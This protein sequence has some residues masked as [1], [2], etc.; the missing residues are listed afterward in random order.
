MHPDNAENLRMS[1]RRLWMAGVVVLLL[2][3]CVAQWLLAGAGDRGSLLV[4]ARLW[5]A[6]KNLYGDIFQPSLPLIIWLYAVP[7]FLSASTG[8]TAAHLLVLLTF[9]LCLLSVR[10]C[11]RLIKLHP[12]FAGN[13]TACLHHSIFLLCLFVFF[14]N[15]MFF[16]DREHLIVVLMFPLFLRCMPSLANQALTLPLRIGIGVMAAL[17]ACIKPHALLLLAGALALRL[18]RERFI[19]VLTGA[20]SISIACTLSLYGLL[21]WHFTSDYFSVVLPMLLKTYSA[22]TKGPE[23]IQYYVTSGFMLAVTLADFRLR[24]DSPYRKDILY[25]LG[26]CVFCL[27]YILVNN[28]WIYTF[29]PLNCIILLLAAWVW[30]EFRWLR[31]KS[32]EQGKDTR[33][34]YSGGMA[35]F[36]TMAVNTLAALLGCLGWIHAALSPLPSP[37]APVYD[38]MNRMITDVHAHS[39]GTLS[40]SFSFWPEAVDKTGALMGTRFNHLWMLPRF[41]QA[42]DA[43]TKENAWIL[44]YV[45]DAYAQDLTRNKPEIVFVDAGKNFARTGKPL[46]LVKYFSGYASF[47][48]AWKHYA[49]A[50]TIDH[51]NDPAVT[52]IQD[53]EV[54]CR[55]DV[56]ERRE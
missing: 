8:I 55:Q 22:N 10:I 33:Q 9:A 44:Q 4:S 39:F 25:F 21:M 48:D 19:A 37:R 2:I 40:A 17:G 42:D 54:W 31:Q 41:L 13:A 27:S 52:A 20:E 30:K 23:V 18:R 12:H 34:F 14:A 24:H 7:E 53:K 29:Y 35:C 51:C 49:L 6:G 46:D 28:G 43:F 32:I 26:L 38:E 50:T 5:L 56:Y 15:C 47:S 36:L 11:H 1:R 16:G 45:A 3:A